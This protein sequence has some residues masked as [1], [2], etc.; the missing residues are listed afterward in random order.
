MNMLNLR[1]EEFVTNRRFYSLDIERVQAT[2]P[3]R[4]RVHLDGNILI[5]RCRDPEFDACCKLHALGMTGTVET[6]MTGATAP[7]FRL[8][9]ATGAKLATTEGN[10]RGPRLT[11]WEPFSRPSD[12]GDE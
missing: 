4:Y 1:P 2:G 7:G 11:K 3:A 10:R 8:D 6:W 5:D 12:D 9:I